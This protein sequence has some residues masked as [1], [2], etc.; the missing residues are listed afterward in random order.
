VWDHAADGAPEHLG[1]GSEVP[2]STTGWV[3]AGLLAEEGGVLHC[4]VG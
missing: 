3:E 4:A 1:W 2:W